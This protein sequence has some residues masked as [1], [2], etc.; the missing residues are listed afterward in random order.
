MRRHVS[1]ACLILAWLCAH[2]AVWNV[3][4]AVAWVNMF[5]GYV[6]Q[7]PAEEALAATFDASRPCDLCTIAQHAQETA[8]DQLPRD[9]AFGASDKLVLDCPTVTPFVLVAPN[10]NW[11]GCLDITGPAR[12]DTVPVPPPRA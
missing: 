4:Q 12:T 7:M 5:R 10:P 8:R 6:Q 9:A 1:I 11:P 2:G 3:V